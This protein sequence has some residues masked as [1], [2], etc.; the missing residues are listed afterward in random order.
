MKSEPRRLLIIGAGVEQ[1]R[2]YELARELGLEVIGTD[3][4]PAAPAL[5]HADYQ[6]IADTHDP[7]ASVAA[8]LAFHAERPIHGVMTIA[9]DVPLTVARVAQA[10]GLPHIPIE[11]AELAI[12]KLAMKDRFARDGVAVPRYRKVASVAEL[13]ACAEEWDL[14]IVTKP[15]DSCGARGVIRITDADQLEAALEI[16]L[17][18][19]KRGVVIAEEYLFGLQLSTE[20]MVWRGK[21]TTASWSPPSWAGTGSASPSSSSATRRPSGPPSRASW[22]TR[23]RPRRSSRRP[24]CG[25]SSAWPA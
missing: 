10:L 18:H 8:A 5:R 25:P 14:P 6:L 2:A 24:G 3:R 23:A 20:G 17:S 15:I 7:D 9:H 12:D 4:N 21:T 16:S 11:A 22:P 1:V 13:R 19:S